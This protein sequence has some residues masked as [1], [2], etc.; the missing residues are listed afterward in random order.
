M[1]G[2]WRCPKK[3]ATADPADRTTWFDLTTQDPPRVILDERMKKPIR[4]NRSKEGSPLTRCFLEWAPDKNLQGADLAHCRS[5]REDG[6]TLNYH[7]SLVLAIVL[8]EIFP[9]I[10]AQGS[11]IPLS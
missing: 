7:D 8:G 10:L 2:K 1:F 4:E 6:I 3:T 11:S 9:K 5:E